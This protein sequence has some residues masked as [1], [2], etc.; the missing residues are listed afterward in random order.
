MAG[1]IFFCGRDEPV[2][3]LPF[4]IPVTAFEDMQQLFADD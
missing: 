4:V 1:N 2:L 3:I